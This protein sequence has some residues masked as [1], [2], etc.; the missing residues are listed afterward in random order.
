MD[1]N[2]RSNRTYF[3]LYG[4]LKSID[5]AIQRISAAESEGNL[6][7]AYDI[8]YEAYHY[9]HMDIKDKLDEMKIKLDDFQRE[10][11]NT[12][13]LGEIVIR[14]DWLFKSACCDEFRKA[15]LDKK[16]ELSVYDCMTQ[17]PCLVVIGPEL[18]TRAFGEREEGYADDEF[19]LTSECPF[20]G[21]TMNDEFEKI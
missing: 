16:V 10:L 18:M 3:G 12:N 20:C 4:D 5:D 11:L 2:N 7:Q 21:K 13:P 17:E 1:S 8:A 6:M 14:T 9:H 19:G 15:I